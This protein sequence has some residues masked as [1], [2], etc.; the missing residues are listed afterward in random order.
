MN[1]D[2][3]LK[4]A[5]GLPADPVYASPEKYLP[6]PRI[7]RLQLRLTRGGRAIAVELFA[8]WHRLPGIMLPQPVG[9]EF[10]VELDHGSNH[11]RWFRLRWARPAHLVTMGGRSLPYRVR[12][13]HSELFTDRV[14]FAWRSFLV[15]TDDRAAIRRRA[16][17]AAEERVLIEQRFREYQAREAEE[18]FVRNAPINALV[19][20]RA[21]ARH[22][23]DYAEADRIRT[24]LLQMGVQVKDTPDGGTYWTY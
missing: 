22:N 3:L 10:R 24:E 9:I 12:F 7:P 5:A 17:E 13:A 23:R 6:P 15:A 8:R 11:H 4:D 2:R 21:Q 16:R 18:R 14:L 1:R 20:R 19:A